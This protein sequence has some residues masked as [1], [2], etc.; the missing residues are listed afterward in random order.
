MNESSNSLLNDAAGAAK[1]GQTDQDG[2]AT[3]AA[4]AV[5]DATT[6]ADHNKLP[7]ALQLG[8]RLIA[9]LMP[10]SAFQS[11]KMPFPD[12]EHY[13]TSAES[14]YYV[15]ERSLTSIAAYSLGCLHFKIS[16]ISVPLFAYN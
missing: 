8:K 11:I 9:N 3:G 13:L 12:D 7:T 5:V 6:V 1:H 4:T 10:S 16:F 2:P 15:N 14:I